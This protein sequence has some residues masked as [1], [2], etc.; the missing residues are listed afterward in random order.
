MVTQQLHFDVGADRVSASCEVTVE[1]GAQI[2]TGD[3]PAGFTVPA[4]ETWEIQGTVTTPANV[5]VQGTLRMRPGATLHFRNVNEAAFVGG[6]MNPLA[7]DVG[8]WVTGA[9]RLD[10][11]GSPKTSWLRT[12]GGVAQGATTLTLASAPQG[13]LAGDVLSIAPTAL[14]SYEDGFDQVIVQSVSG[15]TVTLTGPVARAHPAVTAN[16]KTYT[17]EVFNLTR[18]VVIRGSQTTSRFSANPGRAHVMIHNT[19]PVVHTISHVDM[20]WLGPRNAAEPQYGQFIPGRYGL[21][22]HHC[23]DNVRGTVVEGVVIRDCGSHFFVPHVSH[24]ITFQDCIAAAWGTEDAFWWDFPPVACTYGANPPCQ[25][26]TDDTLYDHCA[27]AGL[28]GHTDHYRL[29]GFALQHGAGNTIRNSV[30]VGVGGSVDANGFGW[31]EGVIE[32]VWGFE[33]NLAHNN[34][35]NGIFWWQV[36]DPAHIVTR[37][38]AYRNG[39]NGVDHGAYR[40]ATRYHFLRCFQDGE[41]VW[42]DQVHGG[43]CLTLTS[44]SSAYTPATQLLF[45][46]V[47]LDGGGV[48]PA[49]LLIFFKVATDSARTMLRRFHV[50]GWKDAPI[51]I[52]DDGEDSANDGWSNIDIVGWY[53]GPE[54]RELEPSDFFIK[55]MDDRSNIRVQRRNGTAFQISGPSGTVTTI[56]PFD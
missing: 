21:H 44:N 51:I 22:F 53:V 3:R 23:G 16:G 15:S 45:E 55:S 54:G 49:C 37:F 47:W 14:A 31:L 41:R 6:G 25:D 30:A 7:S 34:R 38:D 48:S 29:T 19:S 27:V 18:D 8:L 40:T 36:D 28:P 5:I 9:G 4:G 50:T 56:P 12:A 32:S 10:I 46:D 2:V 26:P 20:R 17:P 52:D 35:T 24:G 43:A 11:A 42:D 1:S 33:D 13:W 39:L